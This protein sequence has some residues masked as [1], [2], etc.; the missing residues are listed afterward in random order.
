VSDVIRVDVPASDVAIEPGQTA[1]LEVS[2]TNRQETEDN[3][4]IE[5]EGLDVEWYAIPVPSVLVA[6]GETRVLRVLFRVAR[7]TDVAAGTYPFVV[8]ARGMESGASAVHQAAL[9]VKPFSALQLELDPKRA[10]S[11]LL[12]RAPVFEL[13][14]TN[15]GNRSE[16]LDLSASDAEEACAYEFENDRV[17][18]KPGGTEALG[19]VVEPK[20]RPFVGSARLYQFTV[21]ARSS[22]DAYVSASVHGQLERK[23]ILSTVVASLLLIAAIG[24]AGWWVLRPRPVVIRSFTAEPQEVVA[25]EPVTLSWDIENLGDGTKIVPGNVPVRSSVG[26]VTVKPEVPTIYKLQARGGG[27]EVSRE[28]AVAVKPRPP[29]PVARIREFTASAKRIHQGDVVTLTWRVDGATALVLN[30]IGQLNPKMDKSRQVM[31]EVTTTYVLSAQ[32]QGGDVATKSL[33]VEVVPQNVSIAEIK[34]FRA[35]PPSIEAGQTATLRWV[36]DNAA[37]VGIDNGIGDQL[38]PRGTF[39]V[40]PAVT[41]VYTL[42]ASDSKGNVITRQVT[43]TVRPPAQQPEEPIVP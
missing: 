41:T 3:I 19:L 36:V 18:V 35:D 25:G 27:K 29:T 22:S 39:Q 8:R 2:L 34:S 38:E 23:A 17:T 10:T 32:G 12:S 11:S 4:A 5:L 21:T 20:S 14:V 43:V 33:Q 1:Q 7:S 13:R 16:T 31:P 28:A 24:A 42:R 30:P 6:P 15:M 9:T 40:T 26:S 37:A